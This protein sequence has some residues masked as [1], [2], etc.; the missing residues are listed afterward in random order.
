MS[1]FC[2]SIYVIP[3]AFTCTYNGLGNNCETAIITLH[4]ETQSCNILDVPKTQLKHYDIP[5]F[6]SHKTR[7]TCKNVCIIHII[8]NPFSL[9]IK[10][11]CT[12]VYIHT[13]TE[14]KS[15]KP[16]YQTLITVFTFKG[17]DC[18]CKEGNRTSLF[19]FLN[20]QHY[21]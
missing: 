15:V 17:G 3:P 8:F 18:L 9:K 7:G 12:R 5:I 20:W 11:L 4:L 10:C 16:R 19:H 21:E 6:C 14:E 2:R 13:Y 1:T